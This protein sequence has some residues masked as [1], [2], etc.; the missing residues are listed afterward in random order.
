MG[1][2]HCL[3]VVLICIPLMANV[4][5]LFVCYGHVYIFFGEM[6]IHSFAH[7]KTKLLFT[8]EL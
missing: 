1:V 2:K 4:E 7:L 8:I 6:S 5:H 3:V